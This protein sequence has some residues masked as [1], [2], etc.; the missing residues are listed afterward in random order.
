MTVPHAFRFPGSKTKLI[1]EILKKFPDHLIDKPLLHDHIPTAEYREPFFGSGAVGLTVLYTLPDG[2]KAWINDADRGIADYWKT[3]QQRHQELISQIQS[4]AKP[5]VSFYDNCFI[6]ATDPILDPV[7]SAF[8]TLL[9][10]QC[11]YSGLG[12]KAGGPI[13][14]MDQDGDYK[15]DCRWH[16]AKLIKD[17]EHC[18]T[19]FSHLDL[20]ITHGDF[21]QVFEDILD[22]EHTF[23]YCD[24]PYVK[25]G[26]ELY[27]ESMDATAHARLATLLLQTKSPWVLSYDDD[28]LVRNLYRHCNIHHITARYT[29]ANG[30]QENMDT[31][32][33]H[34][35]LITPKK[36]I[37]RPR[38]GIVVTGKLGYDFDKLSQACG[39]S[40]AALRNRVRRGEM[41]EEAMS[42]P[43]RS[44]KVSE[45]SRQTMPAD[46]VAAD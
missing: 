30:I 37:E 11:S 39:V 28:T 38:Y 26:P 21:G 23:F 8:I 32:P 4:C 9:L 33:V 29:V 6:R 22:P 5:T 46:S 34:E 7:D 15:I 36:I 20:K 41:I 40:A 45:S 3:V 19:Q 18:H 16:P 2:S 31:R 14:G 10:H 17:I 42:Y 1:K 35:L 25:R 12:K 13:G 43:Q 44:R 24:P 27:A